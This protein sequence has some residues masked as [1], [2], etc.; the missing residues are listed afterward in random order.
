MLKDSVH[1]DFQEELDEVVLLVCF[2]VLFARIVK[3]RRS[4]SSVFRVVRQNRDN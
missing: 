2:L 1:L 3:T 4:F